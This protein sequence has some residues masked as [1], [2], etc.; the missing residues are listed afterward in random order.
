M[1]RQL[2]K[3]GATVWETVTSGSLRSVIEVNF[4]IH[5]FWHLCQGK[6]S[7]EFTLI[8]IVFGKPRV[9]K[10]AFM[11][12]NMSKYLNR[13]CDDL[14]LY[15]CCC[16]EIRSI[17]SSGAFNFVMPDH[18]PVYSN[19]KTCF[20]TGYK[21]YVGSYYLD[22][23]HFGQENPYVE[24]FPALPHSKIFFSEAQIY[25]D[26]SHTKLARWVSGQYEQHGHFDLDIWLDTQRPVLIHKN[27]RALVNRF[28]CIENMYNFTDLNCNIVASR[29]NCTEFDDWTYAERYVENGD[30]SHGVKTVY[31]YV[32]NVFEHFE[33]RC[34][35]ELFIPTKKQFSM[36]QHMQGARDDEELACLKFMYSQTAPENYWPEDIGKKVKVAV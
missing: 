35:R 12:A 14:D 31:N 21:K 13:S 23:F 2:N 26:S 30:D 6:M 19:F 9:G 32:G 5:F 8:T 1:F 11:V 18:S 10:T 22:G 36:I 34:Y 15:K 17:N 20:Q 25:Y 24:V 3:N 27:I 28:V 33:S 7:K 29:W 16:D 4:I